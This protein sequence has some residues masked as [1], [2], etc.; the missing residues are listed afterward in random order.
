MK[1]SDSILANFY[2]Q[3]L[4]KLP[5]FKNGGKK[6]KSAPVKK[7]PE[8][9]VQYI[10]LEE[11]YDLDPF[12]RE[13]I[14]KARQ[15]TKINPNTRIVCDASGC[16][17]IAVNAAEAYDYDYN[18]GHAWNLGNVN[19]VVATNPAYANLVGKGILPNPK[20]YS[21][22]ASM[23]VPGSIIGLNRTNNLVGGKNFEN[24]SKFFFFTNS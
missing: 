6:K 4:S 8:Q 10:D 13:G 23:F 16:S 2:N 24:Y 11:Q 15:L 20:N 5:A 1:R 9:K 21:A 18:R 3:E 7:A 17:E 14:D 12:S 22:P 19:N